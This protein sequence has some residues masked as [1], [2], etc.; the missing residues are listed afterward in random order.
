MSNG[1]KKINPQQLRESL[2]HKKIE[3]GLI[4]KFF[5]NGEAARINATTLALVLLIVS[6]I[7]ISFKNLK[8]S[9]DY[10][11]TIMPII[12]LTLGY[13]WGKRKEN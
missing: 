8:D 10:W 13:I 2:D 9:L 6:G 12:T 4:G 1:L 11:K 7:I 5:G 3:V